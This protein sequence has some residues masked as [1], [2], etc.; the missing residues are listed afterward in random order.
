MP[1]A[2]TKPDEKK[3][4][5][6]VVKRM[7]SFPKGLYKFGQKEAKRIAAEQG[8]NRPNFSGY[9]AHLL[10]KEKFQSDTQPSHT[11]TE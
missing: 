10:F 1:K 6:S 2:I 5:S 11:K 8:K 9:L 7:C 4:E 3:G